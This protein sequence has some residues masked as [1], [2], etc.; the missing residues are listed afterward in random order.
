MCQAHPVPK[1]SDDDA[2]GA[3]IDRLLTSALGALDIFATY[4]GDR[5]GFY[6]ALATRGPSTSA[7]LADATGT[8]ERYVREWLEQQ[9]VSGVLEVADENA[10]AADRQ[11]SLP[12]GPAEVLTQKDSLNYLAPIAQLFV[13]VTTPLQK[14][15]D[16]YRTGAGVHYGDY[17]IDLIDG[18]ARFNRSMFINLMGTEW[19]PNAPGIHE[20]LLSD[21]PAKIADIGCGAAWS[22]I[23]FAR[24]YPKVQVDGF[25]L[26]EPSVVAATA[27]VQDAGLTDRVSCEVRDAG[28]LDYSKQYDLVAAFECVHD[29]GNPVAALSA[30][31]NA[32]KEDGYVIV[33]DERVG[34]SFKADPGDVERMMYGWSILHCLPV[35]MVDSPAVGTGTVMRP[36]T[37]KKYAL[38]AG[39]S[40]V[41]ILPIENDFFRFYSLIQ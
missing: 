41:E 35:G 38:E 18:Q 21:P 30:M 15:L 2:A 36:G 27:N 29:M 37:L 24:H 32:A 14:V 13:G 34:E 7:E 1:P 3:Y 11:Y 12:A 23:G 40:D 22:S 4:I 16:A 19:F 31:R 39:F 6:Q 25:D 9:T 26:D 20:R 17:G 10:T 33:I 28:S 8:H 5:L